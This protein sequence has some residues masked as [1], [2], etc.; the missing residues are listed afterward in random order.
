MSIANSEARPESA[1]ARAEYLSRFARPR[2]AVGHMPFAGHRTL[3]QVR[4]D[5]AAQAIRRGLGR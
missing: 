4:E 3:R 5:E 2:A 1:E